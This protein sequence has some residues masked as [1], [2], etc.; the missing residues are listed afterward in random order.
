MIYLLLVAMVVAVG[1]KEV[2]TLLVGAVVIVPA[3]AARNVSSSLYRYSL[4]SAAFGVISALSG[5]LLSGYVGLP[6]GPLVVVAG[7][8][9]FAL[10]LL[11][12][13]L[14]ARYQRKVKV[15]LRP[16]TKTSVDP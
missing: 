15:S 13:S 10:G 12:S 4:L 6:A 1:V 14:Y 7:A 16:S 9:I 3:A 2:G 5:V 11:T 8:V